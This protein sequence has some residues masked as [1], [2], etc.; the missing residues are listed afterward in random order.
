MPKFSVIIPNYNHSTYLKTRIDSVLSQDFQDFEII[1]L[2]DYSTD[3]SKEIIETYRDHDKIGVIIYNGKNTG[4][5]FKQWEKGLKMANGD[6]IWI[7][8]SDDFIANTFLSEASVAFDLHKNI[9]I[10]CCGTNLVNNN[11]EI[12]HIIESEGENDI[13]D[14]KTFVFQ[15]MSTMN[16]LCN[17][18]AIIFKKKFI[19]LPIGKDIT[20]LR[21]CGD[22]LFWSKILLQTDIFLLRKNLNYYRRHE[23]SISPRAIA[24][25]LIHLEGILVFKFIRKKL[26][27]NF[28]TL[29][30]EQDHTWAKNILYAP[31]SYAIKT[32]FLFRALQA[33]PVILLLFI[34]HRINRTLS[35]IHLLFNS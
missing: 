19:Q 22:W 14:G 8:E 16:P 10:F 28:S 25:G 23:D 34:Y 29:W 13:I 7:A 24:E 20:N 11:G 2:D 35:K 6:L 17:A 1:I 4:N 32:K 26:S 15:S 5:T 30:S 33:N 9:G 27:N 3:N 21:Y 31:Y 18:S 12:L